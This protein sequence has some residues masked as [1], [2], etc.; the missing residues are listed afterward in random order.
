MLNEPTMEELKVLRL[1]AMARVW[2]EQQK[3]KNRACSAYP[4]VVA[5]AP[6]EPVHEARWE[7]GRFWAR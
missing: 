7:H 5:T 2:A 1:D 3:S 6:T 4:Y